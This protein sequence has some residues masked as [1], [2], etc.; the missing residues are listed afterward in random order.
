MEEVNKSFIT[1]CL[2][3]NHEKVR[4]A[5]ESGCD[6]NYVDE[7]EGGPGL[8]IVAP[9]ESKN[10]ILSTILQTEGVD[11]N[12]TNQINDT[13]LHQACRQGNI[14]AVTMLCG[15]PGIDPNIQNRYGYTAAICCAIGSVNSSDNHDCL[16]EVLK[17]PEID[18]NLQDYKTERL[19][20]INA[21]VYYR[22]PEC[23]KIL[24][25]TDAVDVNMKDYTGDTPVMA[26]LR[27]DMMEMFKTLMESSKVDLTIKGF[28][29]ETLEDI[30][31]RLDNIEALKLLPGTLENQGDTVS[32]KE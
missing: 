29:D 10:P 24:V 22:A 27:R 11:V 8:T 4:A 26:C 2:S 21:A 23:L 15:E 6:V 20:A 25:Q 19:A 1:G 3:G 17:L 28:D 13:A 32:G 14:S 16:T 18:I 9:Y 30:A 31:R 12:K 7:E 5:I